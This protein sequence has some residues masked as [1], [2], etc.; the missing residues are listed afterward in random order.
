M[1]MAFYKLGT[2]RAS[3]AGIPIQDEM[4]RTSPATAC[5]GNSVQCVAR[6]AIVAIYLEVSELVGARGP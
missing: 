6:R 3:R 5:S 4:P 1:N 2:L